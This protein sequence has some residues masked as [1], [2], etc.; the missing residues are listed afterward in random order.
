MSAV[1]E[2]S[3]SALSP[4][5][6]QTKQHKNAALGASFLAAANEALTEQDP[7][8][9]PTLTPTSVDLKPM[10][11]PHPNLP[12]FFAISNAYDNNICVVASSAGNPTVMTIGLKDGTEILVELNENIRVN[13]HEDGSVSV[14]YA[15]TGKTATFHLDGDIRVEEGTTGQSGTKGNDILV[16]VKGAT[17][18]GDAGNDTILNFVSNASIEAGDGHDTLIMGV[19]AHNAVIDM[20]RGNDRIIPN[21][22]R[23][24]KDFTACTIDMGDGNDFFAA[25]TL[26][27]CYVNMGKGHDSLNA[28]AATNSLLNMGAGDNTLT[29]ESS[30][31]SALCFGDGNNRI[32][33][34]LFD[35][36]S[37]LYAGSG[38]NSLNLGFVAEEGTIYLNGSNKTNFKTPPAEEAQSG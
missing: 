31:Y 33:I 20:G 14:Y 11:D 24:A 19:A 6:Q 38:D 30:L 13:E 32:N 28:K 3:F 9:P 21:G 23:R 4:P 27:G 10:P 16:N 7:V 36:G 34:D 15:D 35:R 18:K 37:T 17:V 25:G 1:G 5:S 29:L 26:T 22:D 12:E 8:S 2:V